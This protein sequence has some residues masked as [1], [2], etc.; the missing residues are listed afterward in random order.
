[1]SKEYL[2]ICV[3][4]PQP[5]HVQLPQQQQQD[6]SRLQQQT[7]RTVYCVDAPIDQHLQ[8]DTARRIVSSGKPAVTYVEVG[9]VGAGRRH[10]CTTR[11]LGLFWANCSGRTLGVVWLE[12]DTAERLQLKYYL[13]SIVGLFME[14]W[15]TLH[16]ATPWVAIL[17]A[18]MCTILHVLIARAGDTCACCPS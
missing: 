11:T 6:V 4:V 1:M 16:W 3:G 10:E 18:C 7:G 15:S 14:A 9:M 8:L 5:P 13:G 2:A 17:G 12:R